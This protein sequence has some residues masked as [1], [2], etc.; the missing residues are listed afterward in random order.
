[1]WS[2]VLFCQSRTLITDRHVHTTSLWRRTSLPEEHPLY[3]CSTVE[4]LISQAFHIARLHTAL[5]TGQ[6]VRMK[7]LTIKPAGA[8]NTLKAV[9]NPQG[10]FCM[11][12]RGYH[13]QPLLCC[14]VPPPLARLLV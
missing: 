4:D 10:N 13:S 12:F 11:S 7:A 2:L 1:M 5:Q 8:E 14:I 3:L 9:I 6:P